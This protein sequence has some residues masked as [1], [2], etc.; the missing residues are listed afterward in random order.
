MNTK[1]HSGFGGLFNFVLIGFMGVLAL[2]L[3]TL[4]IRTYKA[5]VDKMEQNAQVR[6]SL[7][8]IITKFEQNPKTAVYLTKLE[9]TTAIALEEDIGTQAYVTYIYFY[10]GTLRELQI[11]K[12]SEL[13]PQSGEFI[14]S[15]KNL[16]ITEVE[17]G[18]FK[19]TVTTSDDLT[20]EVVMSTGF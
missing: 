12:G 5:T 17:E 13:G 20:H 11:K 2:L 6:T 16:Q 19:F 1:K 8:Y 18:L 10:E 15:I 4:G 14:A 3:I 9:D 7:Q